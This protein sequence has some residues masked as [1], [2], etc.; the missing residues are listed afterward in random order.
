MLARN[1]WKKKKK[2]CSETNALCSDVFSE[3][4]LFLANVVLDLVSKWGTA[5]VVLVVMVLAE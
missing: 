1:I 5:G 2:S 3:D 4:R